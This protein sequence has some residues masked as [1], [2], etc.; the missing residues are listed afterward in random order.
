MNKH[1]PGPWIVTDSG[2]FDRCGRI[3]VPEIKA[4]DVKDAAFSSGAVLK[5]QD[6]GGESNA[7]LIAAAPDLLEALEGL[8]TAVS[9]HYTEDLNMDVVEAIIP[10]RAAIK[11][12]KGEK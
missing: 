3:I 5:A 2:V 4:H 12:A 7:N 1:T 10:A 9:E 11:R 8:L 6:D